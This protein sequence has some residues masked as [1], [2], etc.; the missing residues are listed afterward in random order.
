MNRLL[1][2]ALVLFLILFI[3]IF[4]YEFLNVK[5][6]CSNAPGPHY[7]LLNNSNPRLIERAA[8]IFPE[9]L[10]VV[11]GAKV[12]NLRT[13]IVSKDEND[14]AIKLI[15]PI[16]NELEANTSWAELPTSLGITYEKIMHLNLSQQQYFV[17]LPKKYNGN[18]ILFVHGLGGNFKSYIYLL[19]KVAEDTGSVIVAPT[20]K[21]GVWDEEGIKL[22]DSSI[23]DFENKFNI[24]PTRYVYIGISNGGLPIPDYID[25]SKFDFT[26]IVAIS[27]FVDHEKYK[28]PDLIK[29]L[30]NKE[31]LYIY[32][33]ED[34]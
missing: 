26:K 1:K 24:K 25:K 22:L 3:I 23:S 8:S 27:T 5:Y 15:K 32:G 4:I 33:K 9:S 31:I 16:Y 19:S 18:L 11:L 17:Y 14:E 7:C 10:Q 2:I 21:M 13:D 6:D 30:S 12:L 34:I 29:T 28:Q 20:Y